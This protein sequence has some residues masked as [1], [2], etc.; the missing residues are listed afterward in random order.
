G[1]G[2]EVDREKA[3]YWY[4]KAAEQGDA[5]AQH[6]LGLSYYNGEGVAEDRDLAKRWL[7]EAADRGEEKAVEALKDLFGTT[8]GL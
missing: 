6:N 2:T 1:E 3:V 4:K 5:R 7:T 8:D